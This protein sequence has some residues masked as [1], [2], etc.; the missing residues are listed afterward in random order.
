M[1]AAVVT[2]ATSGIGRAAAL[3]LGDDGW[4]VLANGLDDVRGKELAVEVERRSGGEFAAGDLTEDGTAERLVRR[5]VEAAGRLDLTV[6]S[7]GT[8]FLATVEETEPGDYDRLMATN[9]RGAVLL[10]R[11]A[12]PAMRASGGGVIIN[13]SSEAGIVAVP[14]QVAYN[15][16]KAGL[17][18]LTKSI[19]ADHARDGI[20]AVSICPGT[21]RTPLVERAI[22][23]AQDP[24]AHERWLASSRPA[25]RLGSPD[26][27]AAAVVFAAS[28]RAGYM[29]GSEIVVDGGYTAV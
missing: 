14:G 9:L 19:A 23:S 8:H 18:M 13:V 28:D 27:I 3:A 7:A 6:Y 11:A 29:T 24:E 20:R 17:L 12:I 22:R 21:T 5:A 15:V 26:E 4:W 25:N 1:K 10:A 16:S 2:G